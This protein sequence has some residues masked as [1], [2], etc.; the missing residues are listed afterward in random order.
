METSGS[1]WLRKA[2]GR[3]NNNCKDGACFDGSTG[4]S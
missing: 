3:P 1:D 2:V 4:H